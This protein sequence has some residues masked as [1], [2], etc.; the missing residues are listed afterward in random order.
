[1]AKQLQHD[2]IFYYYDRHPT[3]EDLMGETAGVGE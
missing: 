3:E 2:E 1:M